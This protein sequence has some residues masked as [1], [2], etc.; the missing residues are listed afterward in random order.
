MAGG[1]TPPGMITPLRLFAAL[2]I[3]A[4]TVAV[5][6]VPTYNTATPKLGGFPFFYWYQLLLVVVT[7]ILMV[8]AYWAMKIDERRRKEFRA[9]AP[10]EPAGRDGG[11]AGA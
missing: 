8:A 2:C 1:T 7:G 3:L 10:A 5:I 6:A 4:P 9:A 11:E